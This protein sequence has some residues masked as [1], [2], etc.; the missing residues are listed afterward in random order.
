MT[1]EASFSAM[2]NIKMPTPVGDRTLAVLSNA[3]HSIGDATLAHIYMKNGN[4]HSLI[5]T[6]YAKPHH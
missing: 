4:M 6:F 1:P 5:N 3:T 2:A